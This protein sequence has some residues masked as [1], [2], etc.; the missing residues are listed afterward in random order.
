MD[1]ETEEFEFSDDDAEAVFQR[2]NGPAASTSRPQNM[3][4]ASRVVPERCTVPGR[5]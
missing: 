4:P 5:R 1:E 2:L 3:A